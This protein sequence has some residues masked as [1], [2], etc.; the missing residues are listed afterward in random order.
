VD[1]QVTWILDNGDKQQKYS[2]HRDTQRD[3]GMVTINL[4]WRG[5]GLIFRE[6]GDIGDVMALASRYSRSSPKPKW[7]SLHRLNCACLKRFGENQ[8][9]EHQLWSL[10]LLPVSLG[11][12][13]NWAAVSPMPFGNADAG[14]VGPTR[15]GQLH[16]ALDVEIGSSFIRLL[17]QKPKQIQVK[18]EGQAHID[19]PSG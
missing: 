10:H 13:A 1:I 14:I 4:Y 17:H 12:D 5:W 8:A 16:A 15:L 3:W 18:V 11:F 2:K 9:P 19:R 6:F 7:A